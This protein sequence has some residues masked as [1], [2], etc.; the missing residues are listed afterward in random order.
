LIDGCLIDG[1]EPLICVLVAAMHDAAW[2]LVAVRALIAFAG[3]SAT[4]ALL[5][6][7]ATA[8]A[9][10]DT[11]IATSLLVVIRLVG[12]V[13]GGQIAGSILAAGVGP[14]PGLPAESAFVTGFVVAGVV[15]AASLLVVRHMKKEVQA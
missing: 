9:A 2:Q 13:A 12:A 1:G 5:A 14:V 6:G 15:A 11:G 7:T 10:K 8:V 3:G 4:T